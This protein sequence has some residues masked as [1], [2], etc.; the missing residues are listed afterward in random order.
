M[1]NTAFPKPWKI[2]ASL[3]REGELAARNAGYPETGQVFKQKKYRIL[4][5]CADFNALSLKIVSQWPTLPTLPK[6]KE[7]NPRPHRFSSNMIMSCF[8]TISK[9]S[10]NILNMFQCS[11]LKR[12]PSCQND[13]ISAASDRAIRQ[14]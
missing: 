5:K 7:I 10:D 2:H 13:I 3:I 8:P 6:R 12:G 4:C 1:G 11:T 9:I 14:L